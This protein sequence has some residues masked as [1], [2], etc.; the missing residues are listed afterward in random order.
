MWDRITSTSSKFGTLQRAIMVESKSQHFGKKYRTRILVGHPIDKG[1]LFSTDFRLSPSPC[2]SS[3]SLDFSSTCAPGLCYQG[4]TWLMP[5][6]RMTI[7][8]PPPDWVVSKAGFSS[9]NT[10]VEPYTIH[11]SPEVANQQLI[12][13]VVLMPL[14][15]V[16]YPEPRRLKVTSQ[17]KEYRSR[18]I[19]L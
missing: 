10:S 5:S 19:T 16:G 2:L 8:L 4:H 9:Q 1:G 7:M 3:G 11:H 18:I 13:Y 15:E 12:E 6:W 14:P 17:N